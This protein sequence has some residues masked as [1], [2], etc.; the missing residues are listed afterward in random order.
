MA[1]S[2]AFD[3][4]LD[5]IVGG[6]VTGDFHHEPG[7]VCRFCDFNELCDVRRADLEAEDRRRP[8]RELRGNE[9]DHVTVVPTDQPARE[10]IRDSL[11]E[12]L[13]RSGRRHRQDDRACRPS[14]Q[15]SARSTR[16]STRSGRDVQPRPPSSRAR[17]RG[18]E[19]A[20][21]NETDPAA[22]ERIEDALTGSTALTSRRSTHSQPRSC[23]SVPSRRVSIRRSRSPML[24]RRSSRS[25]P[26]TPTSR[27]VF[28]T[29]PFPRSERRSTAG[30]ASSRSARSPRS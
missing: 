3:G 15:R 30:S 29:A 18:L 17:P 14:G 20:L 25:T 4:V 23:A 21:A 12:P 10:R 24:W 11:H 7:E 1:Q 27:R 22:R 6:I 2:E 26:R 16:P 5:R 13:H 8:S 19:H 9:A 28:L